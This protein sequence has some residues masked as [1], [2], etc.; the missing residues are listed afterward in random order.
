MRV[1]FS[2]II[3]AAAMLTAGTITGCKSDE[4]KVATKP[5]RMGQL[6]RAKDADQRSNQVNSDKLELFGT[7]K[8][9][10]PTGIAVSKT[11]RVFT[12][13]PRWG[14]PVE[15]TVAEIVNG[16]IT[17]FPSKE[18]NDSTGDLSKNLFAVQSVVVDDRDRLWA[19]DTGSVNFTPPKPNAPKLVAIDLKNNEVV[20]TIHFKPDVCLPT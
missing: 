8:G 18:M 17:P 12:N 14:D 9:P 1:T 11:N 3:L 20:K 6:A 19:V 13:F 16:K 4:P 15:Y 7:V 2:S 10:M 5:D